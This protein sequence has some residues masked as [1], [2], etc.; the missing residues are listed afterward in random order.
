MLVIG[1]LAGMVSPPGAAYYAASKHAVLGFTESLQYEVSGFGVRVH[2]IEPG[3]I[4][5]EL[6]TSEEQSSGRI[7]DY[8]DLRS[9]LN[10]HWQRSIASGMCAEEAAQAVAKVLGNAHA[11]FRIRLGRDGVWLPRL[12]ATRPTSVFFWA[13]RKKFG[14]PSRSTNRD[15]WRSS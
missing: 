9:R 13:T 3:F 2:L 1:S 10:A 4:S 6:A 8:D 12:K 14:L 11:P 15:S 7:S 5:T